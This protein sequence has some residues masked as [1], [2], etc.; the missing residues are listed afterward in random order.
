MDGGVSMAAQV[1]TII[2]ILVLGLSFALL[3][4]VAPVSAA[5]T[6]CCI[7]TQG[8]S[9]CFTGAGVFPTQPEFDSACVAVPGYLYGRGTVTT[10]SG[11]TYDTVT[12]ACNLGCCCATS[13]VVNSVQVN[14]DDTQL[15][16][17]KYS[18]VKKSTL[19][20][21][22]SFKTLAKPTCV[23]VCGGTTPTTGITHKVS[24]VVTNASNPLPGVNV[25]ISTLSGYISNITDTNGK[26]TLYEV[27]VINTYV[28]AIH[29]KC[30][31]GKSPPNPPPLLVDGDK[32][33]VNIDLNCNLQTCQHAVPTLTTPK[34]VKGTDQVTF[35]IMFTDSCQ[36]LVQYEPLRCDKDFRNCIA[37]PTQTAP[38]V[39]D[40]E[41]NGLP[42]L[43]NDTT[44]CYIVRA[45]FSDGTYTN[46]SSLATGNCVKTGSATCM[47]LPVGQPATWCGALGTP[48]TPAVVTCDSSNQLTKVKS[49]SGTQTCALV[50]SNPPAPDCVDA[51][52]CGLC[53]GLLGLFASLGLKIPV[54]G[55]QKTCGSETPACYLETS[56]RAASTA[57][58]PLL[59]DAFSSCTAVGSCADYGNKDSCGSNSC[60]IGDSS[61]T[62]CEWKVINE[63]LGKGVCTPRGA[64]ACRSCEAIL[65]YCDAA[66][67][68]KISPDCYFDGDPNGLA[69][70]LGCIPKS[71]MACRYYDTQGDCVGTGPNAVFDIHYGADGKRAGTTNRLTTSSKDKLGFG[72]CSWTNNHCV[73]DADMRFTTAQTEDDCI[74]DNTFDANRAC[75][76]DRA[77]PVT[78]VFLRTPPIPPIYARPEVRTLPFSVSDDM[79]PVDRIKTFVCFRN[80]TSNCYPTESV[81]NIAL[82]PEGEYDLLFYSMDSS[83]N[84]EVVQSKHIFIKDYHQASLERVT[85]EEASD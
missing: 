82:P 33:G 37:L 17:T 65:G 39:T 44:Y 81:A 34:L 80:A 14:N 56:L 24:G 3:F 76:R 36:D 57:S 27:P 4:E 5:V 7:P 66:A 71:E 85:I 64:P 46:T 11:I 51:A 61:S 83:S 12:D 73:K 29:P 55:L 23:E 30:R 60:G 1:R 70:S 45:R 28:F 26:F 8:T 79:T 67:C 48:P 68:A 69:S 13:N 59:I 62:A 35:T 42:S 6:G 19:D 75:V 18:C 43:A 72:V 21:T 54:G 74:E 53:N 15:R 22:Y 10:C 38:D 84:S 49:C 32:S 47:N 31:P 25:F 52:D 63:E 41:S 16:M 9:A 58:K 40:S 2:L 77:P 78:K 20:E 50:G